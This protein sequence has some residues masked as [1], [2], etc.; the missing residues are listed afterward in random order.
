MNVVKDTLHC[1]V[2]FFF[3]TVLY[4]DVMLLS[5]AL[6]TAFMWAILLFSHFAKFAWING[7]IDGFMHGN[8]GEIIRFYTWIVAWCFCVELY[9]WLLSQWKTE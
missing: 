3:Y 2:F 9:A 4:C 5:I 8:G 1:T 7:W 6:S